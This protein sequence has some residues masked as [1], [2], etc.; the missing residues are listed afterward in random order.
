MENQLD[1]QVPDLATQGCIQMKSELWQNCLYTTAA[2]PWSLAF[3]LFFKD[4]DIIIKSLDSIMLSTWGFSDLSC[5][6]F[7]PNKTQ[8]LCWFVQC[9]PAKTASTLPSSAYV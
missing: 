2:I 9:G 8:L 7:F 5:G 6:H 4:P 3:V 1:V